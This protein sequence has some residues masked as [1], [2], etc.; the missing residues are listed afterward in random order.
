[1]ISS[2]GSRSIRMVVCSDILPS[3]TARSPRIIVTLERWLSSH[4]KFLRTANVLVGITSGMFFFD[5]F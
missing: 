1:M 5:T 2:F 3:T 4:I